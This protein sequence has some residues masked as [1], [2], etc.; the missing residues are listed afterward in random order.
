MLAYIIYKLSNQLMKGT[1][2]KQT[3]NARTISTAFLLSGLVGLFFIPDSFFSHSPM[4]CLH[5]KILGLDC[6]GCGLTRALH[7]LLHLRFIT[8]F[9]FNFAVF[10]LLPVLTTEILLGLRF[11]DR[12]YSIRTTFYFLLC[13]TLI[14]KYALQLINFINL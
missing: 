14:I 9:H 7:S 12:L 10:M 5:R 3:S 4:L 6:P 13:I 8:A 2:V 11:T 1:L